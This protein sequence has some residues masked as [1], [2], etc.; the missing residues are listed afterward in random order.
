MLGLLVKELENPEV[1]VEDEEKDIQSDGEV[2]TSRIF[3]LFGVNLYM[4]VM[5]ML[6]SA[7]FSLMQ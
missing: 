3:E 6:W 5:P 1:E 7:T 2:D 4:N